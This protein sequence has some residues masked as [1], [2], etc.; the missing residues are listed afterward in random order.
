MYMSLRLWRVQSLAAPSRKI[1]VRVNPRDYAFSVPVDTPLSFDMVRSFTRDYY[2][3]SEFDLT[4]GAFAG[5]FNSFFRMELGEG[6]H[7]VDGQFPRAI[8]IAR[9]NY[10]IIGHSRGDDPLSVCWFSADAPAT[11]VFVPLFAKTAH[12]HPSYA[13]GSKEKLDRAS[14]WWAFNVVAAQV[15]PYISIMKPD[16]DAVVKKW[17]TKIHQRVIL[18]GN[19]TSRLE[20]MQTD[21]QAELATDWWELSDHLFCKYNDGLKNEPGHLGQHIGYPAAWLSM[22]GFD[23]DPRPKWVIPAKDIVA[24]SLNTWSPYKR[25]GTGEEEDPHVHQQQRPH[26]PSSE[27]SLESKPR[28][29]ASTPSSW[30]T[31]FPEGF[32]TA[33][34]TSLLLGTGCL[35]LGFSLGQACRTRSDTMGYLEFNP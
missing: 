18:A 35:L 33:F 10:A 12:V 8:N 30:A 20:K 17:E 5:P 29:S 32:E 3:G 15:Y 23:R 27:M 16:I 19:D 4:L 6:M 24:T 21:V 31:N 34:F 14:A 9:T 28:V 7:E 22:N 13:V 11:G 26:A 1:E 2:Q 25:K